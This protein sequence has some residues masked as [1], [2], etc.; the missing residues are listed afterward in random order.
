MKKTILLIFLTYNFTA[1]TLD[2]NRLSESI[3]RG[4]APGGTMFSGWNELTPL[5]KSLSWSMK[6]ATLYAI[7]FAIKNATHDSELTA[8]AFAFHGLIT[9][10]E[11]MQ[12]NYGHQNYNY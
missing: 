12:L 5:E 3:L 8:T 6:F 11:F 10:I 4:I 7:P 2:L 1:S 9:F